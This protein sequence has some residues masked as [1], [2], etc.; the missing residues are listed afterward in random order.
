MSVT[1]AL[2]PPPPPPPLLLLMMIAYAD[3]SLR[4]AFSSL[5]LDNIILFTKKIK[6][7]LQLRIKA[8]SYNFRSWLVG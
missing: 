5:L 3:A 1:V 6:K 8:E 4:V 7:Y 2:S